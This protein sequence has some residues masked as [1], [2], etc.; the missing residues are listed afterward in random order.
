MGYT[1]DAYEGDY[2]QG[3]M[4]ITDKATGHNGSTVSFNSK[5]LGNCNGRKEYLVNHHWSD[6]SETIGVAFYTGAVWQ[7][8]HYRFTTLNELKRVIRHKYTG[9]PLPD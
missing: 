2:W 4:V 8:L 3:V 9:S 1:S 7:L 5:N 6:R